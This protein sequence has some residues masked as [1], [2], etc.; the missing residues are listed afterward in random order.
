VALSNARVPVIGFAAPSGT[1]KT[2]LLQYV[3]GLLRER[4]LRIGV[5]KQARADFDIDK[6]GK[7]SY[8]LRKAGIGRLLLA[9]ERQSALILEHP[10]GDDPDLNELLLQFD[11]QSLDVI[12]VEG[13]KDYPF[14]K[15]RL[16]RDS[17]ELPDYSHDPWVIA[18]A[19]DIETPTAVLPVLDINDPWAVADFVMTYIRDISNEDEE[20]LS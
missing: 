13:F 1:G 11:Q 6:P 20:K 3:V 16:H 17:T 7:D 4:G 15:I 14:T 9:S 5:V 19:S 12:L 8:E 2:T 18:V 10:D